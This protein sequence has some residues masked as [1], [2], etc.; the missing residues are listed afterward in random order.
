MDAAA[1]EFALPP[2]ARLALGLAGALALLLGG[3]ALRVH[4]RRMLEAAI[5]EAFAAVDQDGSGSVDKKEFYAA[6]LLLYLHVNKHVR[7]K[8]DI[9][10]RK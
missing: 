10:P 4:G 6:V 7:V 9:R 8:L 5:D 3:V 1:C 2:S